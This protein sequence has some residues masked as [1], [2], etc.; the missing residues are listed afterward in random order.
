MATR[1]FS[2]Q[3]RS[4]WKCNLLTVDMLVWEPEKDNMNA[5]LDMS[6]QRCMR[7]VVT[8]KWEMIEKAL[9]HLHFN[10]KPLML[11][12]FLSS[13]A[14]RARERSLNIV[15]QLE[16]VQLGE[17]FDFTMFKKKN[18][19]WDCVWTV[20]RV[21]PL[22]GSDAGR[23]PCCWTEQ[24]SVLCTCDTLQVH[25][26]CR[27]HYLGHLFKPQQWLSPYC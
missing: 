11:F 24:T 10:K 16:W 15:W 5:L 21:E 8:L 2:G 6:R 17:V 26:L 27:C 3:H 4:K 7:S 12:V 18:V 20:P 1:Y 22:A 23:R 9:S 13:P 19:W 25:K 14:K